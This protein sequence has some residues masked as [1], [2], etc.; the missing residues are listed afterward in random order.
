M[1]QQIKALLC[2]SALLLYCY[3]ESSR[4]I[5]KVSAQKADTMQNKDR[6][7][8]GELGSATGGFEA[9]FLTLFHSR[10][11]GQEACRFQSGAI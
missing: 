5:K 2:S 4:R 8:L 3:V 11:T 9:V 10:V 7:S 1:I 6:L